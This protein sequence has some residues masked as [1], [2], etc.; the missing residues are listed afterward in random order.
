MPTRVTKGLGSLLLLLLLAIFVL[1][2]LTSVGIAVVLL[3]FLPIT[4]SYRALNPHAP[5][6]TAG[7]ATLLTILGYA[8]APGGASPDYAVFNRALAAALFWVIAWF[9]AKVRQVELARSTEDARFRAFFEDAP[10]M[11]FTLDA[12]GS[13]LSVN[14]SGAEQLGYQIGELLG[15]PVFGVFHPDDQAIVRQ[16]LAAC[17]A[18][19]GLVMEWVRRKTRKDGT[20]LWVQEFGR[21]IHGADGRPMLLIVCQDITA[22]INAEAA[23]R[24]SEERFR[25]LFDGAQLGLCLVDERKHFLRVNRAFCA[26]T[27]Y[28]EE[29][30]IGQTYALMTHPDDLQANLAL[31]DQFLRGDIDQYSLE[32]RYITKQ[33][34][35]R[36]VSVSANRIKQP[37]NTHSLLLAVVEDITDRKAAEDVVRVSE[38]RLRRLSH[39]LLETQ[40]N[41]RRTIARDLHDAVGQNLSALKL[42][43]SSLQRSSENIQHP[44][45][46]AESI[47]CTDQL[48]RQIRDL[49]LDL[50]PSVLDDFGLGPAVQWYLDRATAHADVT[51]DYSC[52]PVL[53]AVTQEAQIACFRIL[54][55]A[56]TNCL[57]HARAGRLTVV[58]RGTPTALELTLVDD[59]VGFDVEAAWGGATSGRSMGLL[60]MR[61]RAELAGGRWSIRSA[62][63][64]GT[65]VQVSFP[66][67]PAAAV[68]PSSSDRSSG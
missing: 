51:V 58:L 28:A 1:D 63:G 40:E 32:T 15:R 10:T 20:M 46:L 65:E 24:D 25:R 56:V 31:T 16:G 37:T 54:Q 23:L 3:Y 27:G 41:E 14:R 42:T 59:G 9:L 49:S 47:E 60:T 29:E 36:W 12:E 64:R 33:G 5:L 22:R 50:R 38:E 62:P 68:S 57:R 67:L 53:P 21:A 45:L 30:L 66:P 8:L 19:P 34:Q 35:C 6:L 52:D 48:L 17:L 2:R 44:D 11:C 61:E 4:L 55:E 18:N 43:L 7:A 26:L 13:V 39:L